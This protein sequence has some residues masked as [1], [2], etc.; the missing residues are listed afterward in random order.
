MHWKKL[1]QLVLN[2]FFLNLILKPVCRNFTV[3]FDPFLVSTLRRML[4]N[5]K[6][7]VSELQSL[8][9]LLV[10]KTDFLDAP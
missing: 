1:Q 2:Y 5:P 4:M 10:F 3:T 6:V 8:I 9:D 7:S